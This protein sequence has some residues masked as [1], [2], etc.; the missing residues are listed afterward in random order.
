MNRSFYLLLI[1]AFL[2]CLNQDAIAQSNEEAAKPSLSDKIFWGGGMGLSF[3]DITFVSVSPMVGYR[4]TPRLGVGL[5]LLYT[6]RSDNRFKPKLTTSDYGGN[7]FAQ[8]IVAPPFFLQAQYE[9][10]NYEYYSG[11]DLDKAR[12][13]FNGAYG[14][15]GLFQPVGRNSA[16]FISA[17]YNFNFDNNAVIPGPYNSP[18]IIRV[19]FSAG[20][21]GF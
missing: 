12:R 5:G 4:V 16:F 21:G 7:I 20:F 8:Y 3:G 6:Y 9:Y 18:W 19:G 2:F 13:D 1:S 15:G 11:N 14:G 17:M 10:I